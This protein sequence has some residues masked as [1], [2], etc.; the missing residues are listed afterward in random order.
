MCGRASLTKQEKEL[1]QRFNASF[2]QEDI[3]RYNP[4]PNFNIAP[5]HWHP[6]LTNEDPDHLQFFR[7]GLIPFW[8]KDEKTGLKLINARAETVAD[9][10]A[11]REAFRK[12]RCLVPFDGFYEWKR[13]S[14]G[15]KQPYHIRVNDGDIFTVA[16]LWEEWKSHQGEII[17]SFTLITIAPN[18]IMAQ[19]HDRMPAILLPETERLWL[20]NDVTPTELASL[21]V[22][23][24]DEWLQAWPIGSRIG[25]VREN[26]PDLV[27]PIGPALKV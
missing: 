8:A 26:D 16:G 24:P 18:D 22:P 25:N 12:R 2:Y 11:F 1:E 14:D 6:V 23:C 10:P 17:H 7:W 19:I 21:L 13:Q 15:T 3:A 9:K 20:A 4:L 5:T 27:V